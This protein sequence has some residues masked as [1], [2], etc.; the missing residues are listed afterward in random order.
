MRYHEL[1]FRLTCLTFRFGFDAKVSKVL[2]T[3]SLQRVS[4]C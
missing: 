1:K 2:E 4:K 3:L